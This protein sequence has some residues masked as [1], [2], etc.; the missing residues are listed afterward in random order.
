MTDRHVEVYRRSDGLWDWRRFAGND[1][2]VATSGG[3]GYTERNDAVEAA[4]RENEGL[5]ITVAYEEI[6]P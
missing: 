6:E 1:E 5:T 2:I 3:Q 4:E